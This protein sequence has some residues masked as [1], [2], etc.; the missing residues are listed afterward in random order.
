M[1]TISN[2]SP[3]VMYVR[4]VKSNVKELGRL[5]KW[6]KASALSRC[7]VGACIEEVEANNWIFYFEPPTPWVTPTICQGPVISRQLNKFFSSEVTSIGVLLRVLYSNSFFKNLF[8][9]SLHYLMLYEFFQ[10]R[11]F[12]QWKIW[13]K[14]M[15]DVTSI[16][17]HIHLFLFYKYF[18]SSDAFAS[19]ALF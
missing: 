10:I 7:P 19:A 2:L 15:C 5:L 17:C 6:L 16:Y 18:K 9:F 14:M 12:T 3:Y 11:I 13:T 4:Y 1:A 8:W